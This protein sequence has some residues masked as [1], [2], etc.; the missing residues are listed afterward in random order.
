MEDISLIEQ[1]VDKNNST[2]QQRQC[3]PNVQTNY[4][5]S[6]HISLCCCNCTLNKD[7][8]NVTTVL[9]QA[10]NILSKVKTHLCKNRLKVRILSTCT[11][12]TLI[13]YKAEENVI[14]IDIDFFQQNLE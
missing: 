14:K 13:I 9:H 3:S 4:G 8:I 6:K 11:E 10:I 1:N 12:D 2:K 5:K 7:I